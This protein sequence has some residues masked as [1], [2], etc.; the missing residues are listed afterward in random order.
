MVAVPTYVAS[1]EGDPW[2]DSSGDLA[3]PVEVQDGDLGFLI[4]GKD[5]GLGIS[6]ATPAGW[7]ILHSQVAS[8]S[9]WRIYTKQYSSADD[10]STLSVA[11]ASGHTYFAF[12]Y[13]NASIG[14]KG[15]AQV[16]SATAATLVCPLLARTDTDSALLAIGGDR[17][18]NT[19]EG[20]KGYASVTN[21]VYK[22]NSN[23]IPTLGS[24]SYI[25]QA[26]ISEIAPGSST[27]I[28]TWT[29]NDTSGNGFGMQVELIPFTYA[30]SYDVK[31]LVDGVETAGTLT[32]WDGSVEQPI[33]AVEVI[34]PGYDSVTAMLALS[35]FYVAHRGGSK[36]WP[37]AS[38]FA[39][40]QTVARNSCGAIELPLARTAD[41]VWFGLHDQTLLRTSGVDLNP[42][43]MGWEEVNEYLID[44]S[45]TSDPTQADQPYATLQEIIQIY[46]SSHI[47]FFDPKY[48]S[49]L[50]TDELLDILLEYVSV[51]KLVGKYYFT[52]TAFA[53]KCAA[54]GIKTWG[55]LY[56]ADIASNLDTYAPYWDILGLEYGALQASWDTVLAKGKPVI[57]HICDN[58]AAIASALSKGANGCMVSD[59]LALPRG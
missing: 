11:F 16:R 58:S 41:G 42:A 21:S 30:P 55:Y 10:G 33:T 29:L 51:D 5:D 24:G 54:R 39:V 17:S 20:E 52:N 28:V 49:G 36:N 53:N 57:G 59:V 48:A 56:T 4:V 27:N 25:T 32:V 45:I 12:W 26:W 9:S 3:I 46:G 35:E 18:I 1:V 47:I 50:Y 19:T 15:T 31:V 23:G 2:N 22:T 44:A 7:T 43:N 34:K 38:L 14:P 8:N 37:E 40:T 13:R 6:I